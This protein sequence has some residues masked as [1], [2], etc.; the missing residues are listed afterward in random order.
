MFHV[1]LL[2]DAAL[3]EEKGKNEPADGQIDVPGV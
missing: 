2:L 1:K 3:E